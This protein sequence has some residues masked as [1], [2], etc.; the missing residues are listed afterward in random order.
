[1]DKNEL[2]IIVCVKQ[3]PANADV[4]MDAEKGTLI[5]DGIKT[6]VNPFDMYA[7]EESIRLKERY[8]ARVTAIS[9]GPAQAVE[10]LREAIAMGC[11]DAILLSDK[12]FAGADTLATAYTLACGIRK[13]NNFDMVICGLKTTDG[14]TG[15]VGG[16]LAEELG[17][18]Y[19]NYVRKIIDLNKNGG[20]LE[21]TM[22][23]YY[24]R[25]KFPLPVL[26]TVTKETNEPR[27]ISFKMRRMAMN[28]PVDIWSAND[29]NGDEDRF[30]LDGSPT[31]VVKIFKPKA[32]D[33]GTLIKGNKEEQVRQVIEKLKENKII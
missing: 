6:E 23:N 21:R 10:S 14:D 19:I 26:I 16:S 1:M 33:R 30:G 8:G 4:E 29:L 25:I 20:S 18:P 15:Q 28:A 13:I 2:K 24:E 27:Y 7:I 17:I 32:R 12:K 11:D 31:R 3:V 9:M 5:R 22:D